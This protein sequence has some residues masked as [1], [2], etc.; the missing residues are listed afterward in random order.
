[1]QRRGFIKVGAAVVVS[2]PLLAEGPC[3]LVGDERSEPRAPLSSLS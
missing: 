3:S 1:M 2:K